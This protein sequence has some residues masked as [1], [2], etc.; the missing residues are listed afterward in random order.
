[1]RTE[2][3]TLI[4]YS[5][6]LGR[7]VSVSADRS[8]RSYEGYGRM[9]AVVKIP[10]NTA[11]LRVKRYSGH[12]F[13]DSDELSTAHIV[14]GGHPHHEPLLSFDRIQERGFTYQGFTPDGDSW[15]F[16]AETTDQMIGYLASLFNPGQLDNRGVRVEFV[17]GPNHNPTRAIDFYEY[18]AK[19]TN[20][21]ILSEVSRKAVVV[22]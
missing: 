1:M 8:I 13:G 3:K 2:Y 9:S 19:H 21:P 10:N 11:H 7:L 18:M 4:N 16:S 12:D 17:P 14:R 20:L 22:A 15:K 6:G 5:L